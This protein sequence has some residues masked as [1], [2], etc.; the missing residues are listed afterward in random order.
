[1]ESDFHKR[2]YLNKKYKSGCRQVF[3]FGADFGG[4]QV[5][6]E[7][8]EKRKCA[9]KQYLHDFVTKKFFSRH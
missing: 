5:F 7:R 6:L 9:D 2:T 1:L 4:S 3:P 8:K